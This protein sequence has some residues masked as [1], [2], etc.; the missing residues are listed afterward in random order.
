MS[1]DDWRPASERPAEPAAERMFGVPV[2]PANH[3][4]WDPNGDY[5][6]LDGDLCDCELCES[7]RLDDISIAVPLVLDTPAP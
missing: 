6:D 5:R 7:V 4:V 2:L 3:S 1:S